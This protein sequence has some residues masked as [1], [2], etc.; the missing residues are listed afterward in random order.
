MGGERTTKRQGPGHRKQQH[1]GLRGGCRRGIKP[2]KKERKKTQKNG[3]GGEKG[4]KTKTRGQG[5]ARGQ[6]KHETKAKPRKKKGGVGANAERQVPRPPGPRRTKSQRQR[7]RHKGGGKTGE[8][9]T[10]QTKK[11]PKRGQPQ[12]EGGRRKKKDET[13]TGKVRRTKRRPGGRPARLGQ[14][15]HAHAHTHGTRARRRPTRKGRCRRPH[16]KALV[17]HPSPPS[18]DG[19]YGKPDASVTGSKHAKPPQRT[20]PKTGA[21]AARQGQPHRGAPNGHDAERAKGLASAGASGRHN[22]PGS[23][24]A[25]TCP[26]Q[27]P[28][29]A[30]GNSSRVGGRHHGHGKADR[31]TE[32]DRTGGGVAH[33]RGAARHAREARRR[34]QPRHGDECQATTSAANPGSA[35]NTRRTAAQEKVLRTGR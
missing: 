33:Q 1:K 21:A 4:A 35:H 31:S 20:Q 25:S 12:P 5:D 7:G 32:S 22:E 30:G 3:T 17:H 10:K 23:Q 27:P 18:K 14:E 13:A 26:T 24:P 16:K 11:H 19:P 15:E 29:R 9:Q 6:K 2:E 28:R 8:T 34:P